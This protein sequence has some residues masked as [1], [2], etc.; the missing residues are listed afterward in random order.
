MKNLITGLILFL[1]INFGCTSIQNTYSEV[2]PETDFTRYNSF[3]WLSNDSSKIDHVLYEN[4]FV[5]KKIKRTVN[6]ELKERGLL[7][8]QETP[9][10]L[11]QYSIVMDEKQRILTYPMYSYVPVNPHSI[12]YPFNPVYPYDYSYAY[13]YMYDMRNA[14]NYHEPYIIPPVNTPNLNFYNPNIPQNSFP[15]R[16]VVTGSYFQTLEFDEGSIIIDAIDRKT[17]ELVWRGWSKGAF[18]NADAFEDQVDDVV[19]YIL[20]RFPLAEI[21]DQA[22]IQK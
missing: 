9:D 14:T 16:P 11:L 4:Q 5:T 2:D 13:N 8:D 15:S 12:W 6:S 21:E 1:I 22:S 7:I 20:E 19:N 3:A 10:L 18:D 17:G